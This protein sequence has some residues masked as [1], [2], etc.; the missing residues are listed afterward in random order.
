MTNT[1]AD[2]SSR[3]FT[4]PCCTPIRVAVVVAVATAG[5]AG[6]VHAQAGDAEK[7]QVSVRE[8]WRTYGD[9][10][11]GEV[12]GMAAWPDGTVWVGDNRLA[13]VSEVSADGRRVRVVLSEGEGPR[14]VGR[15]HRLDAL[16][17][18]GMIVRTSSHYHFFGPDK[19]LRKRRPRTASV[20]LWGFAAAPDG[21]FIQS[22]GYGSQA[23]NELARYSVHRYD[24]NGDHQ[25]SW[26]PAVDHDDWEIVR[27]A[28]GG[29]ISVTPQGGLLVSDAAPFRITRYADLNGNGAQLIIEDESIVSSAE[30]ERA[31]VRGSNNSIRYT[32]GWNKSV[33]VGELGN[34]H[35]LNVSFFWPDDGGEDERAHTLWVVVSPDG[36]V[37]A[38]TRVNAGYRVWNV[39]PDGYYLASLWDYD[40][41]QFAAVKLEVSVSEP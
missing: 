29:A 25:R 12:R 27:S 7:R 21:G 18:G 40:E 41:F 26:H 8:I 36:E 11:F 35:I 1:M 9:P 30:L 15:V 6:H 38:R 24:D 2:T 19:R 3:R 23:S 37:V 31:V 4:K 10:G 28:S 17:N 34:A 13:E 39:T 5:F 20:W 32:E 33:Y 22:G 16:P 14:E